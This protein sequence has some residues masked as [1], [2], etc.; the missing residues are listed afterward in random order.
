MVDSLASVGDAFRVAGATLRDVGESRLLAA[1]V[2]IARA[3]PALDDAMVWSPPPGRDLAVSIDAV[4]EDVDFRRE[5]TGPRAVGRRAF[6]VA[7]SDLAAMGA[8]PLHCL[9]TVCARPEEPADN[10]LELQ[11]GLVE[12]AAAQGCPLAG[13]DVSATAGPLVV[14]VCVTG[15][16]PRGAALRRNAGR[17]GDAVAVTGVLGRAAAGLRLL[18]GASAPAGDAE[19]AWVDCQLAPHA[20]VAE[21]CHL[22]ERGVLCG[23]DVSDGLLADLERTARASGCGADLWI[24]R[25]PVDDELTARF[26]QEWL[27]LAVAGGEDFELAITA[28]PETVAQVQAGW[29]ADLAPLTVVGELREGSGVRLLETR[30]GAEVTAPRPAA[31]HFL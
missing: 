31:H 11:R 23:G 15:H 10:I 30:G 14:D 3:D 26:R 25:L 18:Q 2:D 20:R 7:V 29:A 21:G 28:P 17:S 1:L 24:D 12:A 8:T 13:G 4:V 5:W 19:R 27:Q 9:A 6:T 22:L 16:L